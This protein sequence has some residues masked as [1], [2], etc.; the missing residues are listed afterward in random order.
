MEGR[1][2]WDWMRRASRAWEWIVDELAWRVQRWW[3]RVG[4]QVQ[5]WDILSVLSVIGKNEGSW[6]WDSLKDS[7]KGLY[8]AVE[9]WLSVGLIYVW[10]VGC[11]GAG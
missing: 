3:L 9:L 4:K 1:I 8:K 10:C 5:V 7:R 6:D 11:S 2:C